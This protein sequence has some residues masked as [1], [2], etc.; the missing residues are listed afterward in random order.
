MFFLGVGGGVGFWKIKFVFVIKVVIN[1]V[2]FLKKIR[3]N[4]FPDSR[5]SKSKSAGSVIN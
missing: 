3:G 5:C 1:K 4:G 2:F